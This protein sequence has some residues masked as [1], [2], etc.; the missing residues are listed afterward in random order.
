MQVVIYNLGVSALESSVCVWISL[1]PV[2]LRSREEMSSAVQIMRRSRR[3]E[4]AGLLALIQQLLKT[5]RLIVGH[6]CIFYRDHHVPCPSNFLPFNQEH[7]TLG[8]MLLNL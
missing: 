3:T 7:E 8:Q 4:Q 1:S 2:T 5:H 6:F